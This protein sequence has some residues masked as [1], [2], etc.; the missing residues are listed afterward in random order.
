MKTPTLSFSKKD[1]RVDWFSGKG[2]GGQHR[3]KH[4]NCCRITHLPSGLV[5]TGQNHRERHRNQSDAF[6]RLA[7]MVL[8]HYGVSGNE[9]ERV[10]H[11][12]V[13]RTYHFERNEVSDGAV[14]QQ[15]SPTLDGEIDRFVESALQGRR[16]EK[17]TGR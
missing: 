2:A 11:C 12:N 8:E 17:G 1:F 16:I 14:T 3:N 7:T 6:H 5:A 4:Q 9:R 15:V 10:D 13:V